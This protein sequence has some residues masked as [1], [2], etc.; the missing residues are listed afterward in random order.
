MKTRR[1]AENQSPG[2]SNADLSLPLGK[3]VFNDT[4]TGVMGMI[5]GLRRNFCVGPAVMCPGNVAEGPGA[6]IDIA[7][8]QE[9]F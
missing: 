4:V 7:E 9:D 6:L 8:V 2:F 5:N 3:K 1:I